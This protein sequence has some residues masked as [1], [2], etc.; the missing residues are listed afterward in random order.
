[1]GQGGRVVA[2]AVDERRPEVW[3]AAFATGG[4]WITRSDGGSW[5]PLFDREEAFAR[6]RRGAVAN[7]G[8][9]HLGGTGRQRRRSSYAGAGCSAYGENRNVACKQRQIARIVVHPKDPDTVTSPP[10]GRCTPRAASAACSRPA[11]EAAV[12]P[13]C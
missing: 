8:Q 2:L 4:L 13:R 7:R 3:I 1:M 12:G 11:M 9:S 5:E 6:R 10:R